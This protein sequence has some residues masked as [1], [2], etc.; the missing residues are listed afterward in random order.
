MSESVPAEYRDIVFDPQTS[1]GLLIFCR[2]ED[3]E[4][5]IDGFAAE[6]ML[7]AEIG[8]VNGGNPGWIE[9]T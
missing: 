3:A 5:L 8:I 9:V 4:R 7:L 2:P 1:G 6:R